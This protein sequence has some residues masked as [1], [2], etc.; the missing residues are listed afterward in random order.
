MRYYKVDRDKEG[1]YRIRIYKVLFS[2][3]VPV[4]D[5]YTGSVQEV[6]NM[7]CRYRQQAGVQLNTLYSLQAGRG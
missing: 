2:L 5:A 3:L 7:L 4:F 6:N 1:K